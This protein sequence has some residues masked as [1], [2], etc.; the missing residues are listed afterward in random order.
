MLCRIAEGHDVGQVVYEM[1]SGPTIPYLGF[2]AKGLEFRVWN[3]KGQ[4]L[5]EMVG[6]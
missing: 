2:R 5:Y 1:V 3:L 4:V 6:E